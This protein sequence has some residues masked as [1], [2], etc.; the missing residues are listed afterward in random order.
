[1]G[2]KS[3][4]NVKKKKKKRIYNDTRQGYNSTPFTYIIS[5]DIYSSSAAAIGRA[6]TSREL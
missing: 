1:M 4:Q 3:H 6:R 2:T 5:S